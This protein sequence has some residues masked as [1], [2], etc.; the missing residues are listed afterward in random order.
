M[1]HLSFWLHEIEA[2]TRLGRMNRFSI[3]IRIWLLSLILCAVAV[4]L[5]FSQAD[6]PIALYCSRFTGDLNI[7]GSGL[8]SAVILAGEAI[9]VMTLVFARLIRGTISPFAE[10][11]A[12]ACLTS[13]CAYGV[14]GSVLKLFFGVPNPADVLHG[15]K[16]AF[17][18]LKGS[19]DSS[20]PSGHMVLAAAFGG[21]FMRLYR[22]SVWPL[23]TLLLFGAGLLIVGDWHFLS[24]VIA[25]TFLGATVGLLAGELWKVHSNW[26][27]DVKSPT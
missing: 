16:H 9:V 2:S 8:A 10:A 4:T 6:L 22:A 14:S 19:S 20:F 1:H 3:A 5:S 11:L 12:V 17:N 15:S 7:F 24:D 25:G 21:V 23:S 27:A 26:N 18:L 13:I